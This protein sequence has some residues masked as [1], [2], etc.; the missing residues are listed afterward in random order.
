MNEQVYDSELLLSHLPEIINNKANADNYDNF[1][2]GIH[3][4]IFVNPYLHHIIE[5]KKT[6]DNLLKKKS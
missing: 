3:L 2:F 1:K 4:A 6:V 5:G